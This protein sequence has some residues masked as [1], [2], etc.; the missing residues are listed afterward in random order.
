MPI[1]ASREASKSAGDWPGTVGGG[2]FRIAFSS[3]A[4]RDLSVDCIS[5]SVHQDFGDGPFDSHFPPTEAF[6]GAGRWP[7]PYS[8]L[9]FELS[10]SRREVRHI[11][12][13]ARISAEFLG[14][15][16]GALQFRDARVDIL[17]VVDDSEKRP[18]LG[19]VRA[20]I[21]SIIG[22]DQ[23]RRRDSA[24]FAKNPKSVFE[25]YA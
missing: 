12:S 11:H 17:Q 14:C 20:A 22:R 13:P 3:T 7:F 25:E 8:Q 5:P 4:N 15:L 1:A 2:S 18:V 24:K 16:R 21:L 23:L 6:V 9:G 10:N 19:G